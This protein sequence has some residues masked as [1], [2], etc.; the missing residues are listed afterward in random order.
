MANDKINFTGIKW[1]EWRERVI[2]FSILPSNS[3]LL[4]TL[5]TKN[6]GNSTLSVTFLLKSNAFANT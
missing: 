1:R 5:L 6:L 3:K 4:G 2:S